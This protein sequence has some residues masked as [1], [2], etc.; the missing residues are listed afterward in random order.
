MFGR[1]G[2]PMLE[3]MADEP[4][5]LLDVTGGLLS[6][7]A[8]KAAFAVDPQ[9]YIERHGLDD[10][11]PTELHDALGFVADSLPAPLAAQLES[12]QGADQL[13]GLDAIVHDLGQVAEIDPGDSGDLGLGDDPLDGFDQPIEPAAL[14]DDGDPAA[15]G[16]DGSAGE[17]TPDPFAVD[18]DASFGEGSEDTTQPELDPDL[19]I[20]DDL[21]ADPGGTAPVAEPEPVLDL[22]FDVDDSFGDAVP[23]VT[24]LGDGAEEPE[25][26]FDETDFDDSVDI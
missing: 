25:D 12:I 7:P 9:G 18:E 4:A 3:P 23:P 11:T 14:A 1:Q 10:L 6:D 17:E 20:D 8:E 15:P 13:D 16:D 24:P 21:S 2:L 22:A 5:S 19:G 26:T